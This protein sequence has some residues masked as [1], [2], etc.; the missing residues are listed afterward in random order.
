MGPVRPLSLI[1]GPSEVIVLYWAMLLGFSYRLYFGQSSPYK[2]VSV[3]FSLNHR[4]RKRGHDGVVSNYPASTSL[5]W[6]DELST[7]PRVLGRD[8]YFFIFPI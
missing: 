4:S 3:R 8:T 2:G 5:S 7:D 1:I 6:V